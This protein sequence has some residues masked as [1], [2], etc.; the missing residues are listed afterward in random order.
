MEQYNPFT[1]TIQELEHELQVRKARQ[2]YLEYVFL[3]NKGYVKSK[4]HTFL[5]NKVQEFIEKSTTAS[6]D[7]LLLSVPPQHGKSLTVTQTLPAWYLGKH[8]NKRVIIG[9]YN[10]D[11]AIT[12]GRRNLQKIK[13][14]GAEVFPQCKLIDSPCSNVE[15]ETT[16][17]GRCISRGIMSGITGNPADLI[18]I[19]DPIKNREEADSDT[20]REKIWNEYL[21]SIRTR[22][23]PHG[24]LIVIQT[25]WHE[26]DLY[27]RLEREEN[28]VTAI[29]IPCECD[30]VDD[31]LGRNLGDALCPEI[32]RGNSWLK[33]FKR[34]YNSR[35]GSRA[36]VSLYQGRPTQL[37][38]NLF[39]RDWWKLYDELPEN[40]PYAVLSVDA[41][42]KEGEKNDYVAIEYWGKVEEDYYLIDLIKKRMGFVDTLDAIR[43]LWRK[44]P[45]KINYIYIEDKA[46]GS[47]II[48][49]LSKELK[50]GV[51]IPVK[52]EG[53]K[54]ARANA[55]SPMIE[56]GCV[57]LPRFAPWLDDF[58]NECS[59]FPSAAHDDQVDAM[60]Q[61]L[62]RMSHINASLPEVKKHI[63]TVEWTDDMKQDYVHANDALKEELIQM[64]GF[65]KDLEFDE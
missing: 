31:V 60:T 54:V 32:G 22:I 43:T 33:E 28:N 4:F 17:K 1:E 10:E 41:T 15:F 5:C 40:I 9:S 2:S 59:A 19:D 26:D 51:V 24:K 12:F 38:G 13:E 29:N 63:H 36:W 46:N 44:Y 56:R 52:P 27:G 45:D 30:T 64:W 48:D 8:P 11:F 14:F 3:T 16:E 37:E 65:P 49:I 50:E 23:A 21:S 35:E 25:R 39:K 42:F 47:A 7:V 20:T 53:G 55:V 34:V 62:N 57:H 6:F 18:I 61:A 58:M